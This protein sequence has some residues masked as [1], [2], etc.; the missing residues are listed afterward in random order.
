MSVSEYLNHVKTC[1]GEQARELLKDKLENISSFEKD[2][3]CFVSYNESSSSSSG[4]YKRSASLHSN[5]SSF[6]NKKYGGNDDDYHQD[7]QEIAQKY[8]YNIYNTTTVLS[9][10][11]VLNKPQTE[12]V[13]IFKKKRTDFKLL[14]KNILNNITGESELDDC[15]LSDEILDSFEEVNDDSKFNMKSMKAIVYYLIYIVF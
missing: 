9:F 6:S 5:I 4:G 1:I 15:E 8:A 2:D 7:K 11:G 14:K 13:K 3:I 10:N 12:L